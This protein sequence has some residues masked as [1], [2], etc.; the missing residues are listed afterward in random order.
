MADTFGPNAARAADVEITS[1]TP[2]VNLDT[3][4]GTTAHI[5]TGVTVGSGNPAISATLQAWSVTNDGTV[6][7]GNTVK[8]DQGG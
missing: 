7:G 6:T 8:L 1:N 2:S 4:A 5:A 3:F